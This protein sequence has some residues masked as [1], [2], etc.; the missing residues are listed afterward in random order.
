MKTEAAILIFIRST[1][2]AIAALPAMCAGVR[3]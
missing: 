3:L 1:F 2:L